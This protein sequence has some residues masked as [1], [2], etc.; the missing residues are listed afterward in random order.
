M[1]VS[2]FVNSGQLYP[3][4]NLSIVQFNFLSSRVYFFPGSWHHDVPVHD[5]AAW[6]T[7]SGIFHSLSVFK[8][9]LILLRAHLGHKLPALEHA[10][11]QSSE[12]TATNHEYTWYIPADLD[13]LEVMW[14]ISFKVD[15]FVWQLLRI[16]IEISDCFWVF[17][18]D[19]N[20]RWELNRY[21]LLLLLLL[22][23]WEF[24]S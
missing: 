11:R 4:I 2:T 7:M 16:R 22:I 10:I 6:V 8:H 5:R 20:L 15:K 3:L 12:V 9:Q 19:E 23:I 21:L 24:L 17:L 13:H 1:V 14:E 18:E